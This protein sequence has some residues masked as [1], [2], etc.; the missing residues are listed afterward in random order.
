MTVLVR[1]TSNCAGQI[2]ILSPSSFAL[3]FVNFDPQCKNRRKK[4]QEIIIIH[5]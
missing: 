2:Y 3:T 1:Y 5:K 4:T